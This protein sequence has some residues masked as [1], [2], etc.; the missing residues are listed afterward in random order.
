MVLLLI[1]F[2]LPLHCFVIGNGFGVGVQGAFYRYQVTVY[3]N[4]F[5][6]IT[7][8]VGYIIDGIYTGAEALSVILWVIGGLFLIIATF[9]FFRTVRFPQ[10]PARSAGIILIIAG[11]FFVI[12]CI[13]RYGLTFSNAAGLSIPA[14]YAVIFMLGFFLTY[15]KGEQNVNI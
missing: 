3:G 11:I 6:P 5:I 12:S 9:L 1:C 13:S 8:E 2:F 15:A 7:N 10:M 4:S 14:G